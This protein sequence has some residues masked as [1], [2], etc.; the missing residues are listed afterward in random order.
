MPVG[1]RIA[2]FLSKNKMSQK[3][4]AESMEVN[5][6]MLNQY[7]LDNRQPSLDVLK[8]FYIA[9]ISIDWLITGKG[10]MYSYSIRGNKYWMHETIDTFINNKVKESVFDYKSPPS[11]HSLLKG[12]CSAFEQISS[13]IEDHYQGYNKS[14]ILSRLSY[15]INRIQDSTLLH[16][17]HDIFLIIV[18]IIESL[19][20][21]FQDYI[22]EMLENYSYSFNLSQDNNSPSKMEKINF[23]HK[24]LTNLAKELAPL[25]KKEFDKLK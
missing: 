14:D 21:D 10:R 25:I 19:T 17:P 11:E 22:C 6:S 1:K 12:Y 18:S 3:E 2:E 16:E 8:K 15:N 20:L 23:S 9:G 13:L 24:D 4:L 5:Y 7:V